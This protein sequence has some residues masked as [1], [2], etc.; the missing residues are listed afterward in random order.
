MVSLLATELRWFESTEGRLLSTLILDT[1]GEFSAVFLAADLRERFRWVGQT[2]FLETPEEA[3]AAMEQQAE[4]ILPQLDEI[5]VQ[6]D[7]EGSAVDFFQQTRAPEELNPD[8]IRLATDE[9]FS[10]ARGI[11]E[12]MMRWYEDA[13][14]NFVEQFQTTGFDPRIWE[15]YLFATINEAGFVID[16]TFN[17]PDITAVG[18][19]GELCIEATTI[20]PTLDAAGQIVPIPSTDT[21]EEEQQYLNEYIPIRYAGPLT[22][23]LGKHYW[24]AP[25]VAGKP[26]ALAIHDFHAPMS[27]IWS[28]GGLATYLYGYAHDVSHAEDGSLQITPRKVEKHRWGKKEVQ[29]G[30]FDLPEAENISA[31][32]FNNSATISKFNRIGQIA[33]FGSPRVKLVRQGTVLDH[34]PNASEPKQFIHHIDPSAYK[35]SWI[36]GMDVFHNPRAK[37]PLDPEALPGAAHHHLR[38]DLSVESSSPEWHPLGSVTLISISN[39][40]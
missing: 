32:I 40:T 34:N 35:E 2:S 7:E 10:P 9:G 3:V 36:E 22:T 17:T 25:H 38:D 23:K 30:F 4:E 5:R 19:Q 27:M 14:G 29:A 16:R 26:F 13:D 8:F 33:G 18:L 24:E 6:G 37:I 11:I 15:L 31:V 12:P 39:E 28:R 21:P 1:D 20:N